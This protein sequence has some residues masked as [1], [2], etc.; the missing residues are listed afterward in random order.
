VSTDLRAAL[1]EL[2]DEAAPQ[3]E[4]LSPLR[5]AA[6]ARAR[7][8][9]IRRR[10]IAGQCLGALAVAA[11]AAGIIHVAP[12]DTTEPAK[13]PFP[14]TERFVKSLQDRTLLGTTA[15]QVDGDPVHLAVTPQDLDL[16]VDF[17]CSR[18][19]GVELRLSVAAR[20]PAV[21]RGCDDAVMSESA[22]LEDWAQRGLTAG[23]PATLVISAVSTGTLSAAELET[24][25]WVFLGVYGG[26]ASA[27]PVRPPP[28]PGTAGLRRFASVTLDADHWAL[29]VTMPRSPAGTVYYAA[30]CAGPADGLDYMIHIGSTMVVHGMCR[31]SGGRPVL[32]PLN[33]APVGRGNLVALVLV[34]ANHDDSLDLRPPGPGAEVVVSFYVSAT[35]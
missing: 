29:P 34:Q 14:G 9:R 28:V 8:R 16:Q 2:A 26:S 25:T 17:Y 13:P 19:A 11:V 5:R 27:L 6:L 3:L 10:R 24:P 18:T 21:A 7:A 35:G 22:P 33:G 23:R 1:A 15:V 30:S 20:G 12:A 4:A 31:S 32:L